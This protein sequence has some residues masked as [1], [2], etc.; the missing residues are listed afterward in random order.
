MLSPRESRSAGSELTGPL[1]SQPSDHS[2]HYPSFGLLSPSRKAVT[3]FLRCS[4][5]FPS[6]TERYRHYY[7]RSYHPRDVSGEFDLQLISCYLRSQSS[8]K[9][10][11]ETHRHM[12]MPED[13]FSHRQ[14]SFNQSQGPRSPSRGRGTSVPVTPRDTS[15]YDRVSYSFRNPH[16]A[17]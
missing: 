8:P 4:D 14:D 10:N 16:L 15:N 6:M 11:G 12:S 13:S 3:S 5:R 2:E 17:S 9:Y 7:P 1:S